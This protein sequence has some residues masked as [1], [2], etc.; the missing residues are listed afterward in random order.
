MAT[1]AELLA[2]TER[3]IEEGWRKGDAGAVLA[4]Y[5]ADFVDLSNPYRDRGTGGDNVRGIRDLYEAFP[6]FH[7]ETDDVAIDLETGKVAV[8][9][10][11]TGTHR[12]EFFGIAPT[13][14]TIV[15]HGI[16]ILT[17]VDGLIVERAGEWDG[18]EIARQ[19]SDGSGDR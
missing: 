11:A 2:I 7:A 8:R 14:R 6:D 17:I 12:G 18:T 10:T 5:A 13:G 19:I 3:W 16:E 9:W 15:F 1:R 4:M